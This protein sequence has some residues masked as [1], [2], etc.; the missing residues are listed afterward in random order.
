VRF[1]GR[2]NEAPAGWRALS[3]I[4]SLAHIPFKEYYSAMEWLVAYTNDEH[5]TEL[6]KEKDDGR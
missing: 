6:K 2:I 4:R 3:H 1:R 5:L